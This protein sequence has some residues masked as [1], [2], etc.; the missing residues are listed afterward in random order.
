MEDLTDSRSTRRFYDRISGVYDMLADASEHAMRDSGIAALALT[1]GE[2]ALDVGFGTGHGLVGMARAVGSAGLVCGIDVSEGMARIARARL[3]GDRCDHVPIV[4]GDARAL[5]FAACR[6]DAVFF[7][8]TLE[9]FGSEIPLVLSEAR[10][11][12]RPGGR[13]GIVAMDS[14]MAAG[15]VTPVYEWLHHHFP[16][17][18]D[19]VPIDVVAV[20]SAAGFLV[21]VVQTTRMWT[22]PV[23]AVVGRVR[24][25]CH[26]VD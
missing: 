16:H 22:L 25:D 15:A 8:F 26:D 21:E 7:S 10:R 18:V 12:L 3:A 13:V 20:A 17:A 4:L 9:R 19:C 5:C 14:T 11:V 2:R 6:F 1:A 24:D 23:K